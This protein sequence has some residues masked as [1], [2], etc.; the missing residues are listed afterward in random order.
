MEPK[1]ESGAPFIVLILSPNFVHTSSIKLPSFEVAMTAA[2]NGFRFGLFEMGGNDLTEI[3]NEELSF[4]QSDNS[5]T[6]KPALHSATEAPCE[7][8]RSLVLETSCGSQILGL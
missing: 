8:F 4:N 2:L 1:A 5:R 7:C 6:E 3:Y